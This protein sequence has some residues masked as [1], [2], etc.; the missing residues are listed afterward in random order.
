[1]PESSGRFPDED[2][3]WILSSAPPPDRW[4]DW[5]EYDAASWPRKVERR[6]ALV[7]TICFNCESACGLLAYIDKFTGKI[8]RF[9]GNPV[10]P[11]SR[12]RVCAKGPATINQVNDPERVLYPMKRVGER[13]SGRW[14]RVSWDTALDDLAGRIRAAIVEER[15]NEIIYHVG[16]PGYDGTMDRLLQAW[17]V[18]GHNSHTNVCSAA[19]RLGYALWHHSD[20]PSPDYERADFIL[21]LSAHLETGHYFN[22]HA[23]RIIEARAR[24]ARVAVLDPRLSNTASMADHWLPTWP[25]SEAA[26]LLAMANVIIDEGLHD[27]DFV[28]RWVNWEA[29]LKAEH[30]EAYQRSQER[31]GSQP[32]GDGIE[33]FFDTLRQ[34]YAEFTP[35]FAAAESGVPAE[36]IIEVA[37]ELGKAAPAVSA[38]IWRS[39]AAGNEGGWQVSRCL[40]W[41]VILTGSFATPGGTMPA[42]RDKFVAAPFSKPP[43][44]TDWNDLCWPLEYPLAHYEMSFLL[45]HFLKENRGRISTYFTRVYNPAWTNPDGFSWIEVLRDEEKIG[46]HAALTPTWNE[47]S[48]WADYVLPMGLAP[49]RHDIMSQETSAG[50]WI[51]F[52]QP[53]LRTWRERQGE[54]VEL[55]HEANPGEVW[56]E[57][58]FWIELSWRIDPDGSLGIRQWFESPYRDGEKLTVE[59]YYRWIFENSVPGL[60]EAASEEGLTP[61]EYMRRYGAFQVKSGDYRYY[62]RP[63]ALPGVDGTT[64]STADSESVTAESESITAESESVTAESGA[65]GRGPEKDPES[66]IVRVDGDVVGVEIDGEVLEGVP[67]P[68]RKLEFFSETMCEWGWPDQAVPNYIRS[69]VHW[70][71]LDR[72]AGE[73]VLLPTF[74]LPTLVHT[75]SANA[76]WLVEISHRNPLW[77]HPAD[78]GRVGIATDDLV[79]INTR[80]GHF[81]VR[82]WVTEGLRPGIIACSHHIGRWRLPASPGADRWHSSVVELTEDGNKWSVR[83]LEGIKP[84]G[85]EDPDSSRIWWSDAGVHQNL[86][87]PVQPDPI[88][89]MHCW[90]QKVR[91]EQAHP[92]DRYGDIVVD[93]AKSHAIYL[94]WLA[95]TKPAPGPDGLRR[96]LWFSRPVRPIDDAYLVKKKESAE[97]SP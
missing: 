28:R 88:S 86:A 61:L 77:M 50:A 17:G 11:G 7:P 35:E 55:S 51:G 56:E 21:L 68:S 27:R 63:V 44:Q 10:H 73:V 93:T 9:E 71:N 54:A 89:G 48:Y 34:V 83:Q 85:S 65:T 42:S 33:V 69:H 80:I 1:M 25:G 36:K 58:E 26:V 2:S 90:H 29:Y 20:R 87:F 84:F 12:G 75:R 97:D 72:D 76:K 64:P 79:R 19:A 16:R 46:C 96:P 39:A 78:A 40:Q 53:V 23:Q 62:D 30:P 57:D 24:G 59:E 6:Y 32:G 18:D 43:A 47:S 67:T 92:G 45:P 22:P 14:V 38:H 41:L 13:G 49:E 31:G 8:R 15:R 4:D 81:V 37:R 70:Q 95:R 5:V 52:R 91:L 3:G 94:E 82:A 66:G 74:R 60:P